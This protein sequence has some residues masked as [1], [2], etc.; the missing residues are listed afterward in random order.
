MK[1]ME[2]TRVV[3]GRAA[4]RLLSSK[5]TATA[6]TLVVEVM[7]LLL[8]ELEGGGVPVQQFNNVT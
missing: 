4:S 5:A 6:A 3:T 1:L 2:N 8:G 7:M